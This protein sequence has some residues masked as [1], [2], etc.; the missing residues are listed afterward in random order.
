MNTASAVRTLGLTGSAIGRGSSR[1][2]GRAPSRS[3]LN[4]TGGSAHGIDLDAID[5]ARAPGVAFPGPAGL[6]ADAP[7]AAL[8]GIGRKPGFLGLEISEFAAQGTSGRARGQP[9]RRRTWPALPT[10]IGSGG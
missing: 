3:A 10:S 1:R 4:A 7:V 6:D 5:P 2:S 8:R 9:R